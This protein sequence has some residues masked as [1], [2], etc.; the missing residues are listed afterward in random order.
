MIIPVIAPK[1]AAPQQSLV[2]VSPVQS[3]SA[4]FSPVQSC[5]VLFSP[6]QSRRSLFRLVLHSCLIFFPP[7]YQFYNFCSTCLPKL[8]WSY[9][10][11][12]SVVTSM[13]FIHVP[14]PDVLQLYISITSNTCIQII[15]NRIIIGLNRAKHG[16]SFMAKQD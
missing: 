6:V 4:L 13:T 15:Q 9:T 3:C 2:L 7:D 8:H 5:S 11:N 1:R 14:F 12:I 10:A 16:K